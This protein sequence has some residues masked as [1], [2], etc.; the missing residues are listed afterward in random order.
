MKTEKRELSNPSKS[1][2]HR[3]VLDNHKSLSISGVKNV[4]TF[5]DKGISVELDGESLFVGGRDLQVKRLD[6]ENGDLL[7]SG[8]VTS[9]KYGGQSPSGGFIKRLLK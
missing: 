5:T 3:L 2:N 9:L 4:P 6:V 8:Y 1:K 7:I